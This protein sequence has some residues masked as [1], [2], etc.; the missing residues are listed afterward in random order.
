MACTFA[1]GYFAIG[2]LVAL[3]AEKLGVFERVYDLCLKEGA[4]VNFA[5]TATAIALI[6]PMVLGML[7]W[8]F[9]FSEEEEK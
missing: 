2:V 8:D 3:A 4:E 7:V 5:S 6:W 1:I 9:F